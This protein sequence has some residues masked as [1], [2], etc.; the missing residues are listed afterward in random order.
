MTNK[1]ITPV[2]FSDES[3]EKNEQVCVKSVNRAAPVDPDSGSGSGSGNVNGCNGNGMIEVLSGGQW[4]LTGSFSLDMKYEYGESEVTPGRKYIKRVHVEMGEVQMTYNAAPFGVRKNGKY[5]EPV[6]G[7]VNFFVRFDSWYNYFD[8]DL[9]EGET[10][11]D[12]E[13]ISFSPIEFR[14]LERVYDANGKETSSS[15][16]E[17]SKTIGMRLTFSTGLPVNEPEMRLMSCKMYSV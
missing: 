1:K 17:I 5:Y 7:I 10:I 6:N 16:L 13:C 14:V 3:V 8:K 2:T 9:F 12:S 4:L 11:W 15:M